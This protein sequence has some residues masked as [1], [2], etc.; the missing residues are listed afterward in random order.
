MQVIMGVFLILAGLWL[1]LLA[2]ASGRMELFGWVIALIGVLS[3]A[4]RSAIVRRRSPP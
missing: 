2:D 3:L 4:A 1:A